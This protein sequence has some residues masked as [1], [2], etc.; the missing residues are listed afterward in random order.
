MLVIGVD[1]GGTFTD[2][3][4]SDGTRTWKAKSPT[5]P[6]N[7]GAGVIEAC[8]LIAA[9]METGPEDLL[10]NIERFGL[11]TT[12]VTNV[13]ATR[14]G[15]RV[16]LLTTAGFERH[17]H[18]AR[19]A[20]ASVDGWLDMPWN[21][22]ASADVVGIDERIDR[23]GEVVEPLDEAAVER[24]VRGLREEREVQAFAVSFLWSCRNPAHETTAAGIARRLYPELPVFSGVELH[25]IQREYER[26]TMAVLNAYA[27]HALDGVEDLEAD[28]RSRGLNVP[29]LL[30]HSGGGA[31][32]V[33]D[34]RK[35]P[36][37]LASSGPAAGT[38]AA[39]ELTAVVGCA[40][41]LCCDVGGTSFDVSVVREGLPERRQQA[42][43]NG[44]ETGVSS[45][46]VESIG[47]GGGSMAWIDSRG[48]LRVGPRS[49]RA[50]PGPVCYGRGGTVPTVTD[51]N[52]LLGYISPGSF[53]SGGIEL[54]T[55]AALAACASLGEQIGLSAMETAF[56]I[57]E[58]AIAEMAKAIRARM[59]TSGLDPRELSL[60]SIGGSGS[61]FVPTIARELGFRSMIASEFSSV[62]S[63]YGAASADMRYEALLAVD[64]V[65]P[66]QSDFGEEL[67]ALRLALDSQLEANGVPGDKRLY[68]FEADV[69]LHRQK[70]FIT[71]ALDDARIDSDL[72]AQEFKELY[73]ERYGP[74]AYSD[75]T[76]V[77]L[78]TLRVVG[79][80]RTTRATLPADA[81]AAAGPLPGP[82]GARD[83][84]VRRDRPIEVPVYRL[85]ALHAGHVVPGPALIDVSDTTIWTP[86]A[87]STVV[88]ANRT[89]E[90]VAPAEVET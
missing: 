59:A 36:L 53:Q 71:L 44:L 56:G 74:A 81:E 16:G 3:V 49:A 89:V 73:A 69:R 26:T 13:L 86:P 55:D 72:L 41:A 83:V 78:S 30:L 21:P 76:M 27:A 2:V 42:N 1:V 82:A 60:V 29:M 45:V 51:S 20:R 24:A 65:L 54:D 80:G 48:M 40:D 85:D 14:Q 9:Q 77:E 64:T 52:L 43:V 37:G 90:T 17:L 11:G 33:G 84:R 66:L 39:G 46:D 32:T 38:V 25:P 28:L 22:V 18:L 50:I 87:M 31:I 88:R 12:A 34:A 58:I 68:S 79:V 57:R 4:C 35:G 6:E 5:V 62:L 70:A 10:G 7:F 63:A 67:E 15:L 47:A 19:G 61:L 8:E 75:T 23:R